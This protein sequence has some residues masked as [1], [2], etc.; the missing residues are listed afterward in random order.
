MKTGQVDGGNDVGRRKGLVLIVDDEVDITQ[1][2]AWLFEWNGFEALAASDGEQALEIFEQRM[3]DIVI[4][5]CM[6]PIM[7]GVELSRRLR[8]N[9]AT[10]KIPIVLMS[11]APAQHNLSEGAFD[12]FL[13]KP[14]R[15]DAL[16]AEVNRLLKI[17]T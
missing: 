9:P 5:D 16:L 12:A 3:P 14:F 17:Q 7:D 13:Q 8:D 10:Q 4:S 2:F 15:F 11:G 6:M 1:T